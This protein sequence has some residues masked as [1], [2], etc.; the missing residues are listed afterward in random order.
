MTPDL[1]TAHIVLIGMMGVGKSTVGRR[2][3]N[4]LHRP[5]LDSDNEVVVKTGRPVTEIFANDGE[6]AF[7]EIEA[8]VMAQLFSS[9]T[10]AVIAAAGGSILDSDTRSL[11]K[12]SGVVVWMSAPVDVLVD[13]TTRGTHRPALASDPRGTL[14]KME[15]VRYD[16]YS[17]VA[18]VTVDCTQPLTAVVQAVLDAVREVSFQ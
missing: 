13:R 17:E 10:P 4:A 9:K 3:A 15:T 12:R 8:S 7:R 14:A 16:L 6:V 1:P 18:D 5:F 2:V 11:M